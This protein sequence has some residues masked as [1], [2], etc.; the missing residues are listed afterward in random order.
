MP[1]PVP[2]LTVSPIYGVAWI[3]LVVWFGLLIALA[4]GLYRLT[5]R[6]REVIRTHF[7]YWIASRPTVRS[8]ILHPGTLLRRRN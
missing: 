7:K 5:R 2:N 3:L 4:I 8:L 1:H 6:R